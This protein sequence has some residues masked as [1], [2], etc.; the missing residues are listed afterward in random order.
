[1]VLINPKPVRLLNFMAPVYLLR[2]QRT[3]SQT[4]SESSIAPLRG[5][6]GVERERSALPG[7]YA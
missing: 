7:F 3:R 4:L 5:M 2:R 1:M 6:T